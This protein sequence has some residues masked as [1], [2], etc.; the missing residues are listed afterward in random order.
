M[1]RD[2]TISMTGSPE[3]TPVAHLVA[4]ANEYSSQVYLE[5]GHTRVNAKSIMGMMS[6]VLSSGAL[7]T[8]EA[9]GND[10]QQAI[11]ALEEFL[12]T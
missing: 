10:E 2:V 6:L 1:R 11:D 4:L 5:M 7:V 9:N 3:A 12:T 8:V